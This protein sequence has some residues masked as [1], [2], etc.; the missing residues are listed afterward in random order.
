MIRQTVLTQSNGKRKAEDMKPT[1]SIAV[2][3]YNRKEVLDE[4]LAS[5]STI[6]RKRSEIMVI[7]NGSIDGTAELVQR[8]H[9]NVKL[10]KMPRNL[11]VDGRNFGIVNAVGD[12][13]ITLDD[14]I[15][16]INDDSIDLLVKKFH[17]N[18]TLAAICFQVRDYYNHTV[19]NWCH[20]Y[21]QE[22]FFDQEVLTTEISEGAVAF[23]RS[24][25]EAIGLYP[26][27]FFISHEGADL[28]ARIIDSG[29]DIIYL[30]GISVLHKYATGGRKNWRR[31]YYDARNT[32]FVAVR[33]YRAW[34]ALTHIFRKS[35]IM[36][37]YSIRDGFFRYWLKAQFDALLG[38]VMVF[39]IRKPI[40]SETE[41]KIKSINNNRPSAWYYFKKR[42]MKKQVRI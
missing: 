17:E 31:Y 27:N 1:V 8:R 28:S 9:P 33:N 7:D 29:H 25:F 16:G 22:T 5:L 19:C 30:P 6:D 21:L 37:I 26:D 32:Y 12:I 2:L 14:D 10:I 34:H 38:L 41:A 35:A 39:K 20:P 15:L 4:L 11:G 36:M 18:S 3:T 42:F 24:L 40:S 13:L 23:R